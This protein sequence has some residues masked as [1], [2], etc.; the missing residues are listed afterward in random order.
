MSYA[1]LDDLLLAATNGWT[2][3]AQRG[4]PEA[5][6]EPTL[7][8]AVHAGA[9]VSAWPAEAVVVATAARTRLLAALEMASKHADTYLFPRYRTAM[10]LSADL[11][12]GSS[13]PAAVATIALK[14]LYGTALPEEVRRGA[15]WADEYLRDIAKA[16]VSLGGAD[17]ATQPAGRV[18]ASAPPSSF[19]WSR[20]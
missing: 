1:T 13:L 17:T 9:D 15:A 10:P 11:V 20:Y 19:D 16:V 7:L 18:A 8:K 2:E 14:R 3:L 5:V 4:A 12:Q 6:L